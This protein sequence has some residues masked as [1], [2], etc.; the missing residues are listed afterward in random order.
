ILDLSEDKP[1]YCHNWHWLIKHPVE[2]SKNNRTPFCDPLPRPALRGTRSTLPA[3]STVSNPRFATEFD[4]TETAGARRRV[5]DASWHSIFGV[6]QDGRCVSVLPDPLA[7]PVSLP[8][9]RTLPGRPRNAK[10][11][12]TRDRTPGATGTRESNEANDDTK[13]TGHGMNTSLMHHSSNTPATR[14]QREPRAQSDHPSTPAAPQC[15]QPPH[16]S[17]AGCPKPSRQAEAPARP[18]RHHRLGCGAS[19]A[20]TRRNQLGGDRPEAIGREPVWRRFARSRSGLETQSALR[21]GRAWDAVGLGTRS[22]LEEWS[23]PRCRVVLTPIRSMAVVHRWRA[24][25]CWPGCDRAGHDPGRVSIPPC[26]RDVRGTQIRS[27]SAPRPRMP[28]QP[29]ASEGRPAEK[30]LDEEVRPSARQVPRFVR[31]ALVL[32]C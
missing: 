3:V 23:G 19:P 8:A 30:T 11:A 2:F 25:P 12:P 22:G 26:Q 5:H 29:E 24:N 18:P 16:E 13:W 10:S 21:C 6:W 1:G 4:K 15:R 27:P 17:Q 9:R 32:G 14:A 28:H 20:S 7:S 31:R